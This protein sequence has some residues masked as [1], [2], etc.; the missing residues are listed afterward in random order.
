MQFIVIT[1]PTFLPNEIE[2]IQMLIAEG[3]T[4][5]HLRKPQT[6]LAEMRAFLT[7]L[8]AACHANLI[9]HQHHILAKDYEVKGLHFNQKQPFSEGI[10]KPKNLSFSQTTHSLEELQHIS[11]QIDYVLLSPIFQS[12]SKKNY[13]AAFTAEALKQ[14]FQENQKVDF[15]RIALGGIDEMTASIAIEYGFEG[16][17]MLGYLWED[18]EKN[19]NC[20]EV[21][22]KWQ[23]I[24]KK[25]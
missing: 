20:E 3:L 1:P 14:Y 9:L 19:A 17:A 21:L 8:P 7:Q 25:A 13:P 4:H 5:L 6:S 18:F 16:V 11:P 2:A 22:K 15:Q 10:E 23:A 12:I 24:T